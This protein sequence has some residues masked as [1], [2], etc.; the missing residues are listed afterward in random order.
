MT[1]AANVLL[2]VAVIFLMNHVQKLLYSDAKI[3]LTEVVTQN[4]DVI[5]SKLML[6]VNNLDMAARQISDRLKHEPDTGLDSLQRALTAYTDEMGDNGVYVAD[7]EGVACFYGGDTV[8]IKGRRYFRLALEGKQNTSDRILSRITG[9]D[10]F[11]IS[12]PLY[13]GGAIVGTVQKPYLPQEMYEL[14]TISLFSAQGYMYII[15]SDGYILISSKGSEYSQES[16][17]YFRMVYAQ[18]NAAASVQLEEDIRENRSG[19]VETV[20]EGNKVF[21]AYTPIEK[22]H[23]WYLISSVA[24]SAV[25][26]NSNTVVK[27]FYFILMALVF[28]FGASLFYFLSYKNRQQANLERIA[29]VDPITQ[30]NTYN[31]FLVDLNEALRDHPEKRYYL[32]SVDIDN[33]KYVN[34][35]YGFDF[36]DRVLQRIHWDISARL[37]PTETVARISGDH[38]VVLL[39]DVS[40]ERLRTLLDQSFSEGDTKVY[41]SAGLYAITDVAESANLMVDKAST[42]AQTAKTSLQRKIVTYSAQYDQTMMQNE[43]LKREMEY[44]LARREIIPFYQPKVDV[45]SGTLVGAEALARWRTADGRMVSPGEFIP[46]CEK[47][48]QIVDVDFAIFE[49]TLEFLA[50]NLRRGMP[51]VPISVN[52]SRLHLIGEGFI[53]RIIDRLEVHRVPPNLIQVELTES[54]FFNSYEIIVDFVNH[55][56]DHGLLVCIDDFGSGFSSLNMLKEIPIDVLKIDKGFLDETRNRERQRIILATIAEMAKHLRIN[57]VVEGVE[58]QENVALMKEI[59][60]SVAQ[61]YFFARPMDED[62]FDK[63]FGRGHV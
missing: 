33:F 14:C 16:D 59:G 55:L 12:V 3:N 8:N 7:R 15:N 36:G 17:N 51:C 44:A 42:A 4:K 13:S 9:E 23:D 19:F 41:L 22:L 5:N 34:S 37:L 29:F 48:G 38:F 46:L 39:E 2:L 62:S 50:R 21:S 27:M 30:G 57:V 20:M 49:Q 32:L 54:V 11:V 18:G 40:E 45:D 60:C 56:H 10:M 1:V 31:K 26:P 61:G 63:V 58:T 28:V 47:T 25:S 35:F 43:R 6:E 24:T 52:F 53:H